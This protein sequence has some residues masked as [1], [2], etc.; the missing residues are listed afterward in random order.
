[1]KF[2]IGALFSC[3]LLLAQAPD[4]QQLRNLG[5]AFYEN[6]TTQKEAVETFAKALALSDTP[7][8]RLNY[9][10]ALLHAGQSAEAL[11]ELEAVQKLAPEL[12][13]T[14]FTIG[15]ERKKQGET[16]AALVQM[17]QAARLAPAEAIIHYNVGVLEKQLGRPQEALAAF[18]KARSLD[19]NLAA[20]HFQLYNSYRQAQR[21]EDAQREL[22]LFQALKKQ[23]EGAAVPEDVDWCQY[24][25]IYDPLPA[26]PV[27]DSTPWRFTDTALPGAW[28]GAA[29][30]GEQILSWD[31][32]TLR[33]GGIVVA[34]IPKIRSVSPGDFNNDGRIDLCVASPA[35]V[36]LL[37]RQAAAWVQSKLPL[38]P[39]A[40][41]EI[42][43]CLFL[44]Y[45][46]DYDLD[47]VL[48]GTQSYL[49]RNQG[50]LGFTDQSAAFPFV[51]APAVAAVAFRSLADTRGFDLIVSYSDQTGV[52]YKDKLLGR[53][54]AVALPSLSPGARELLGADLNSDGQLDLAFLLG[55]KAHVALNQGGRFAP[56]Q[57]Q[58][59]AFQHLQAAD[60]RRDGYLDLIDAAA[61]TSSLVLAKTER[62]WLQRRYNAAG[63]SAVIRIEGV[64]NLLSAAASEIEVKIG[65]HYQKR[66]YEGF[67]LRFGLGKASTM[68]TVRI[69]WPN[70]LIQNEVRQA[71]DKAL[72]YKEA[73]RLSG[74]CPIVWTWN[75]KEF[76][77]ITDVL[78]VAPLGA[79]AG[80]GTFFP[81]D[82]DE[83]IAIAGESLAANSAG[84]L[85]LR[86]TEELSEAA[87]FDRARLLAIDHPREI[88][89]FSNEKWKAPPFPDFRL[90]GVG[91][92]LYPRRAMDQSGA[93]VTALVTKR[94]RTYPNSFRRLPNGIA[95]AHSL[96]LDFG[97]VA[98][99]NK[100]ILV[101]HGWVDWADGS[102]F[103]SAAQDGSPLRGP[104]LQVRDEAG[105]WR[106][107]I[108]DMGMPSGKPKTITVDLTGKFLSKSREIRILTNL[109]VYWDEIFLG[110]SSAAPTLALT[111]ALTTLLPQEASLAFR[112]FSPSIIHPQRQQPEHFLYPNPS[113]TSLWDPTPGNYTRYGPV[114]DLVSEKDD[115]L[116]VMGSGD[117]L[118]LLFD[119][120]ALPVLP[121]GWRRDYLLQIDGW[122]KDRD[123]NT[124]FGQSVE[125]LPFHSMG[126]Y[127]NPSPHPAAATA[128]QFNQRPALRLL[129]PLRP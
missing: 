53:Y 70:G 126:T 127:P 104:E 19:A 77:Y 33:L 99:E 7:R 16:E 109:C 93:N 120:S 31:D 9:G 13:H 36:K 26:P 4:L 55:E 72:T 119:A 5:K 79:S 125:P 57:A 46:H 32:T 103:L 52:L 111:V 112:G 102:T 24:S 17:R 117:E 85:E 12:P 122:A 67:P 74:S 43:Q 27:K 44:D 89:I 76:E 65:G 88:E 15:I 108:E 61:V 45:D 98:G 71:T 48:I 21:P 64:K 96:T 81:T 123:A 60:L 30:Y 114:R 69:T 49:L 8:E 29:A 124:A 35:G 80:D 11:R 54:E 38:P 25:E 116:A 106:T 91:Q 121:V 42:Q 68:D 97:P 22:V 78:G 107:V 82:S 87:Y 118:R 3:C 105:V 100:A 59:G 128:E 84:L 83:Y 20:A 39:A 28:R 10:L 92:R 86:L 66:T 129:R 18:E 2:I 115:R 56:A 113:P 58:S 73:Q 34:R 14:W 40:Q 110:E 101:L 6:P 62:G 95:E 37:E 63:R 1:M 90:Y 50:P 75:G 94:D 47:L 23:T 51:A 41:A